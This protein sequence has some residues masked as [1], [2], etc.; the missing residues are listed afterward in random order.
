MAWCTGPKVAVEFCVRYPE[1]VTSM[2]FLN[3]TFKCFDR[4][5]LAETAYEHN[6]ESLCRVVDKRPAMALSVMNSLRFKGAP[7][8]IALDEAGSETLAASVLSL[9]N[10]DLSSHVLAP[11]RNETTTLNY[12]RQ[13]MDFWSH[14]S[15]AKAGLVNV[16][17]LLISSEYDEI[18]SPEASEEA[19]R[20][21]PRSWHMQVRGATHYC[22]YD[23]PDFIA[24]LARSFCSNAQSFSA[25]KIPAS[26]S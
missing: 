14:D 24:N 13:L 18:A 5:D 7:K 12:V 22:L 1:S 8:E 15:L 3:S 11:F 10:R 9:I 16:P 21:L 23:R 26:I 19:A 6:L 4:A 17:V 25:P 20:I 2:L